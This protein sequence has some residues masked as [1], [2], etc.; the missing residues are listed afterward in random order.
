ML[1]KMGITCELA[2]D[3][4]QGVRMASQKVYDVIFMDIMMPR[5]DGFEATQKIRFPFPSF[6]SFFPLFSLFFPFQSWYFSLF[7]FAVFQTLF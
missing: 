3:G 4:E 1:Q 6:P 5:M 2:E 7:A